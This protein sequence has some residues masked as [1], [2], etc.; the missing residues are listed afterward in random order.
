[1][2]ILARYVV[3]QYLAMFGLSMALTTGIFVLGDFFADIGDITAHSSSAPL[4]LTYFLF[5]IPKA[6]LNTYPAA[7]LLACLIS[8]GLMTRH[9]EI[10]AMRAC[11]VGTLRLGGR[12][13]F[14]RPV[15]RVSAAT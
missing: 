13:T 8:V 15:I 6:V 2:R 11:G 7:A 4:V 12:P 10:L 14:G 3:G 1:M 9:R 5:R